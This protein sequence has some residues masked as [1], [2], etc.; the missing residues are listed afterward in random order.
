MLLFC[1]PHP[2]PTFFAAFIFLSS[3]PEPRVSLIFLTI[4]G[5]LVMKKKYVYSQLWPWFKCFKCAGVK[6]AQLAGWLHA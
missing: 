2:L 3:T 5:A 1:Y 4:M 6:R